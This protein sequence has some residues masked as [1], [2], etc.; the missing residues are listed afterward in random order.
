M[1]LGVGRIQLFIPASTSLKDKRRVVRAVGDAVRHRCNVGLAEV[2]HQDKWQR[3]T[4]GVSCVA[5]SIDQCR[6][7]MQ[8]VEKTMSRA[9]LDGAEITERTYAFVAMDDLL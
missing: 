5:G 7:V 2:G 3:A 8:Q 6:K 1:F 4:L 9:A